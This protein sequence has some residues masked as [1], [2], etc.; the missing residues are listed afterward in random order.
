MSDAKVIHLT[1][2]MDPDT[3]DEFRQ[4]VDGECRTVSQD[5]RHYIQKRLECAKR[6]EA[7]AAA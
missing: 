6:D 5:I 3:L 2:R 1:V 4:L 7:R